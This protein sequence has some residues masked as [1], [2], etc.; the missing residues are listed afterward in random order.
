MYICSAE[1]RDSSKCTKTA[2][3]EFGV[4]VDELFG[5]LG[6]VESNLLYIGGQQRQVVDVAEAGTDR[7]VDEQNARLFH[8]VYTGTQQ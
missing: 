7:T 6:Q 8:L 1:D 5:E 4:S 3:L 2:D